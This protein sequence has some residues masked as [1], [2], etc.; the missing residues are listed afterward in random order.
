MTGA[1]WFE[2][3]AVSVG[4]WLV[5]IVGVVWLM[6]SG[7]LIPRSIHNTIVQD[8][9]Q[10][11]V[12]WRETARAEGVRADLAVENQEKLLEGIKTSNALI[13]SLPGVSERNVT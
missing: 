10:Q 1:P 13:R 12:D 9:D 7:R 8:K 5:T 2:L 4:G 6:L 11:I 3:P